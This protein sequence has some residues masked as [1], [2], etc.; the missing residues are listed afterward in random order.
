MRSLRCEYPEPEERVIDRSAIPTIDAPVIAK[1][2]WDS[3]IQ[4]LGLLDHDQA[5]EISLHGYQCAASMRS[6][7]HA[8]AARAGLRISVFIRGSCIYAWIVGARVGS[9][10]RLQRGPIHCEVCGREII[11]P[12]TGGSKQFVCAGNGLLKSTC[13]KIR[14]YSQIHRITIA[15][16]I[17][18]F[19]KAHTQDSG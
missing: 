3:A 16:A 9:Q 5:L 10:T 15:E 18:H 11:R 4:H 17:E 12:K 8:A 1:G 2:Y 7:F 14:R 6:S 13:Q 19:R